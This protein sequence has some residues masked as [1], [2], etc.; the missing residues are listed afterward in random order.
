MKE[1]YPVLNPENL[2]KWMPIA[3]QIKKKGDTLLGSIE[4]N[5][6]YN[7][8]NPEEIKVLDSSAPAEWPTLVSSSGTPDDIVAAMRQSDKVIAVLYYNNKF[9]NGSLVC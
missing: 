9:F 2:L 3:E 4:Y 7:M 8:M 1:K 5:I 6:E